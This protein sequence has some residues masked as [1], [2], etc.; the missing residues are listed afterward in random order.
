VIFALAPKPI[1]VEASHQ[2]ENSQAEPADSQPLPPPVSPEIDKENAANAERYAYYKTH[3]KEYLKAAIA[4]ANLSNWILAGLGVIGG[5]LAILTLFTIKRQNDITIRR[6]RPRLL[7]EPL[8]EGFNFEFKFAA[9]TINSVFVRV[10]HHGIVNAYNVSGTA[11]IDFS[12]EKRPNDPIDTRKI[13]IP[14]T[15]KANSDPIEIEMLIGEIAESVIDSIQDGRMFVHLFGMI[16]YEDILADKMR[17]TR[18]RYIWKVDKFRDPEG[19]IQDDSRWEK[20][21]SR[22]DNRRT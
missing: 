12:S 20:H 17:E 7:V 19:G 11:R 22:K 9:L 1:P 3:K 16:T 8:Y 2:Q 14:T 5:V 6:E 18:F 13:N 4:P 21:G 10:T 15:I